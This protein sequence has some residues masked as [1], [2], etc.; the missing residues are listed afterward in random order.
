MEDG[1]A[2]K[3]IDLVDVGYHLAGPLVLAADD[4][5]VGTEEVVDGNAF[6][7]EFRIG[8]HREPEGPAGGEKDVLDLVP[9]S[10]R[11]GGFVDDHEVSGGLLRDGMGNRMDIFHVGVPVGRPRR[12][13][14]RDERGIG[15]LEGGFQVVR[16][17]EAVALDVLRHQV[18]EARFVDRHDALAKLLDLAAVA[19]DTHHA[20]ADVCEAGA[21]HQADIAGS[22]NHDPHALASRRDLPSMPDASASR[23]LK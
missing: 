11:Y 18:V 4:D 6:A 2:A 14:H 15:P 9:G 22:D 16:E 7:K 17:G 10:D 23:S 20:V 21:R 5:P 19:I 12:R 13:A 8:N 3:S 1:G